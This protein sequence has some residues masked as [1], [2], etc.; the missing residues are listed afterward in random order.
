MKNNAESVMKVIAIYVVGIAFSLFNIWGLI[1]LYGDINLIWISAAG[2]PILSILFAVLHELGHLAVAKI[3]RFEIIKFSVLCFSY[4]KRKKRRFSLSFSR[5]N[6]GETIFIPKKISTREGENASVFINIVLGG[7]IVSVVCCIIFAALFIVISNAYARSI[8]A[9]FPITLA[10]LALNGINGVFHD[11]DASVIR[12]LSDFSSVTCFDGY[13]NV[14]TGLRHG[15]TYGEIDEQY[16]CGHCGIGSVND[17]MRLFAMRRYEELG[18]YPAAR[19][20]IDE[21]S[22][23]DIDGSAEMQAEIACVAYLS[24]DDELFNKYS[25]VVKRLDGINEPFAERARIADAKKRGDIDYIKIAIKTAVK[26]C[27]EEFFTGDGKFNK[28][29]IE[30][31]S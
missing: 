15:K 9:C 19:N 6:L 10:F 3:G 8:L 31:L 12:S 28:I 7:L 1:R 29:I 30:R 22:V 26:S 25:V 18:D 16:F 5:N 23:A 2:L 24:G 21:L 14:L 27:D 4:D 20:V 11:S 13:L 17:A